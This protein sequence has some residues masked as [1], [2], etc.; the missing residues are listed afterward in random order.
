MHASGHLST[1]QESAV[2]DTQS[3]YMQS[4]FES[5]I[6]WF[7]HVS[8]IWIQQSTW[9]VHQTNFICGDLRIDLGVAASSRLG[10]VYHL[11]RPMYI[12]VN[13]A[14]QSV[15]SH[16]HFSWKLK[17]A[18]AQPSHPA[19]D[20]LFLHSSGM[21]P[22]I[23]SH[24]M[25]ECFG[26]WLTLWLDGVKQGTMEPVYN[27]RLRL[28]GK[29]GP[30]VSQSPTRSLWQAKKCCCSSPHLLVL[31]KRYKHHPNL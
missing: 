1:E 23:N 30:W 2:E 11:H 20:P 12:A 26:A 18:V 7:S 10:S 3:Q 19:T 28:H 6:L 31:A 4:K 8:R 29:H 15:S 24:L 25:T 21:Q 5:H 9:R 14:A 27:A 16:S 22:T 13:A 17:G